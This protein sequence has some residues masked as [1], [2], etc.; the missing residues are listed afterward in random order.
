MTTV[1]TRVLSFVNQIVGEAEQGRDRPESQPG[2]M[3]QRSCT[4]APALGSEV[5]RRRQTPRNCHLSSAKEAAP[6]TPAP[7][8][9]A[10][11]K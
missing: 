6:I 5:R 8:M 2:P 1:T 9:S 4:P 7:V 10:R 3:K 11:P